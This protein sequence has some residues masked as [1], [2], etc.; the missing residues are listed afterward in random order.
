MPL[1][2]TKEILTKAVA[3]NYAVPHINISNL[4]H[5]DTILS[6]AAKLKSPIIVAFTTGLIK[7]YG[8]E[9]LEGLC[10]AASKKYQI[11]FAVHLDHHKDPKDIFTR[12]KKNKYITSVMIDASLVDF[13]KM[14]QSQKMWLSFVQKKE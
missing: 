3:Q 2:T 10:S 7:Y 14:L 5:F 12:I 1:V 13:E 6:T 11:P 9:I 4:E 8:D